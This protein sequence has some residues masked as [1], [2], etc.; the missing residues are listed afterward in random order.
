MSSNVAPNTVLGGRYKLL[1]TIAAGGMAEVWLAD[2]LSLNRKVAVKLLK[3][4]LAQ[5]PIVVERFR[6]EAV[7]AGG[8]SHP[9]IVQ[10]YD[11]IVEDGRQAVVMQF[12]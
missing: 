9:N 6:R 10:V 5:D 3:A 2:D 8:L 4:Q 11:A 7:A 1:R 12:V